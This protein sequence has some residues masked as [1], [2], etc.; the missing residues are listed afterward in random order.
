MDKLDK[1]NPI[2]ERKYI[3]ANPWY[4]DNTVSRRIADISFGIIILDK[5]EVGI[6]LVNSNNPREFCCGIFI[7][8]EKVAIIMTELYQQ[9]WDKAA[10]NIDVIK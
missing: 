8:D 10:E 3:V 5:S 4:P 6:E 9:I 2:E 7:R 1:E